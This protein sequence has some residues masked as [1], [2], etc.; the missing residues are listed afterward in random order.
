MPN[1][2][3][4]ERDFLIFRLIGPMMAFGEITVGERRSLWDAPSK[5]GILGLVAACLGLKRDDHD[6]LID[7]DRTLGFGV[8]VDQPGRPLRDYHTAQTPTEASRTRRKRAGLPLSTRRD[9][10]DGDDLNTVLSERLY[11]LEAA[12]TIALWK[13][14]E[15]SAD[16]DDLKTAILHPVFTPYLGRKACPLGAPPRPHIVRQNE[17]TSAF[18]AYD[19]QEEETR[20]KLKIKSNL[21]K[22]API[23][24]EWNAGLESEE[25]R[26]Q[27]VRFR[28]DALRQR[29]P[30]QFSD[31][32]EGLLLWEPSI[33]GAE[34]TGVQ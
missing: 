10:L 7:L 11:R 13:K 31:R 29:S 20:L 4:A 24:F 5:S 3:S 17:L 34:S 1:H 15:H 33:I 23:W 9:D 6:S 26:A 8:R 21:A 14:P 2:S 30:W 12:S 19:A 25:T 28:R 32:Q 18:R 27:E 22:S 16:L